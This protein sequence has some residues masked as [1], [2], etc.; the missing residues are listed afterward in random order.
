MQSAVFFCAR[1]K[2]M[3]KKGVVLGN[4]RGSKVAHIGVE[5]GVMMTDAAIKV[6]GQCG[7]V[8]SASQVVKFLID[9]F[10]EQAVTKMTNDLK[11]IVPGG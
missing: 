11:S 10:T 9:N 5:R 1:G 6:S 8:V 3:K 2:Y 4:Q 7:V